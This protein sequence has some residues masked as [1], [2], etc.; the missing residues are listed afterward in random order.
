MEGGIKYTDFKTKWAV[1]PSPNF[2]AYSFASFMYIPYSSK[3][4]RAKK[5]Y[6][7]FVKEHI[8]TPKNSLKFQPCY[9]CNV[10]SDPEI[11]EANPFH[12]NFD[13]RKFGVIRYKHL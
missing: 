2:S 3:F 12:V 5:L 1:P 6:A 4:S 8:I 11:E 10:Q 9:E 7:I 13:P